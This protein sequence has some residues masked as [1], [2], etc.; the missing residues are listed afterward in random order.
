MSIASTQLSM[1]Y[2][3]FTEGAAR[4]GTCDHREPVGQGGG[5]RCTLG[6]FYVVRTGTCRQHRS[7]AGQAGERVQI[8]PT[9]I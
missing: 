7:E 9:D 4:C 6:G 8:G 2:V 5:L 1:G 3:A